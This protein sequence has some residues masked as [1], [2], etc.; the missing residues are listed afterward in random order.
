[1]I[2]SS[3]GPN[4]PESGANEW[5]FGT[6]FGACFTCRA[7]GVRLPYG[8]N[9]R[10]GILELRSAIL[11]L[12][13][14]ILELRSAIAYSSSTLRSHVVINPGREKSMIVVGT[15]FFELGAAMVYEIGISLV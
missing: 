13:A 1:M 14:A 7:L 6:G 3:H 15:Q 10:S 4:T 12:R 8:L 11:E 9:L 5:A 2:L